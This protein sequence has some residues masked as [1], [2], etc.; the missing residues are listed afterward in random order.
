MLSLLFTILMIIVFGKL[1]GV[2]IRA[3]WGISKIL[4]SLVFLPMILIG[5]VVG[6]LIYLAFPLALET[7]RTS[8]M[9]LSLFITSLISAAF[10]TSMDRV[11]VA[12]SPLVT[13]WMET[14]FTFKVDSAAA[15]SISRPMRSRTS[16]VRVVV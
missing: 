3:T 11:M 13:D 16:S 2:A 7:S 6:G 14:T 15:T 5:L 1:I 10:L 8:L 9:E 4:V 12:V